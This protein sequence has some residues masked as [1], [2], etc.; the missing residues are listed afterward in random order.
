ME[1]EICTINKVIAKRV[2]GQMVEEHYLMVKGISLDEVE[3]VFD[4]KWEDIK[5]ENKEPARGSYV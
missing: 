2:Q 5:E 1:K 3:K 4:R